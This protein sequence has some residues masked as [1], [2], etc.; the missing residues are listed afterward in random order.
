M[1]AVAVDDPDRH[2]GDDT[3]PIVAAAFTTVSRSTL[4]VA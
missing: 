4:L 3:V 1:T 2:D